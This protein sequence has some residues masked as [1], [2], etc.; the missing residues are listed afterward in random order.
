M[1]AVSH[2][3]MELAHTPR[4]ADLV[5]RKITFKIFPLLFVCYLFSHLDRINVSF[6]K[7]EFMRDLGLGDAAYGLGAGLFFIGYMFF[8]VP[9]NLYLQKVGARITFTRIMVIWGTISAGMAF[10]TIPMQFYVARFLLGAA[11]AGFFPGLILYLTYWFP[12]SRRARITSLFLIGNTLAAVIGGPLSGWIMEGMSGVTILK[13]WQWLFL[14]EGL[15]TVALGIYAY[16]YLH[17]RPE[18][19]NW[20]TERERRMVLSE[21]EA[22]HRKKV[23]RRSGGGLSQA[24]L[25]PKVYVVVVVYFAILCGNNSMTLWMP[26]LIQ[27]MGV[28]SVGNIGWLSAIPYAAAA[29][30]MY[31][32]GRHSDRTMERRWHVAT[33]MVVG[34]LCFGLLGWTA[35]YDARLAFL[36]VVVGASGIYSG[37]AVFWTIPP[38]Y[39]SGSA[40]AAGIALVSSLGGLGGFASPVIIGQVKAATGSYYAGF[41]VIGGI[42]LLGAITLIV[43]VPARLLKEK[44]SV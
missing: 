4:E 11:E 19:V 31:F 20:L 32:V 34:A 27:T 38:A 15:P 30:A 35:A 28:Q 41:A 9:S 8:E 42:L 23:N 44:E 40:A 13:S 36:L 10:V 6:A 17:D 7:L 39:L 33:G 18:E 37:F 21:I 3:S 14:L 43:G 2:S 22:D 12:A 24:F 25:D 1:K 26:S 16:F 29:V 5:F